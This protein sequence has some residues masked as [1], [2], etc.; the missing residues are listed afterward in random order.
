MSDSALK[1]GDAHEDID[2]ALVEAVGELADVYA[3]TD[4]ARTR[5]SVSERVFRQGARPRP[6]EV[7]RYQSRAAFQPR[8]ETRRP[9]H[10]RWIPRSLGDSAYRG[11]VVHIPARVGMIG[12][13]IVR[14]W[15]RAEVGGIELP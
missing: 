14:G 13:G 7:S 3:S 4:G 11:A 15:I 10:R 2:D 6:S 5:S 1:R 9:T 8:G 12:G